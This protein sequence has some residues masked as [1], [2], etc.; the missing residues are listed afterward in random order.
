MGQHDVR[1]EEGGVGERERDAKG[2]GR[3]ADVG[4][5]VDAGDREE[6]RERVATRA[7]SCGGER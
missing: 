5:E 4:E 3:Q 7:R 2:L 1:R 6:Q